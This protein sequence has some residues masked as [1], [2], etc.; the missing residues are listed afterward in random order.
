MP[1]TRLADDSFM[2]KHFWEKYKDKVLEKFLKPDD[3]PKDFTLMVERVDIDKRNTEWKHRCPSC[4][5]CRPSDYTWCRAC[6][7]LHFRH[8]HLK[9]VYFLIDKSSG[10]AHRLIFYF[11]K[12]K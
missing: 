10:C 6:E 8:D 5:D 4:D 3:D 7:R 2:H 11:K 9:D 1:T 12:V